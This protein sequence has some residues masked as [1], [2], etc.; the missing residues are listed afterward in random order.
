MFW[1]K[2]IWPHLVVFDFLCDTRPGWIEVVESQFYYTVVC[3]GGL[4]TVAPMLVVIFLIRRIGHLV[5]NWSLYILVLP[6]R[7]RGLL[8]QSHPWDRP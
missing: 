2:R 3:G 6:C 8:G 7:K 4:L 5:L 1:L